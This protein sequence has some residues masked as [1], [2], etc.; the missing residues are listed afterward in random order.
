MPYDLDQEYLES[1]WTGECPVSG[2]KLDKEAERADGGAAELDRINPAL[3]Y[4]KG[5]VAFLSR[6]MNRVKSDVSIEEL[7]NLLR[8]MKLMSKKNQ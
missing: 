8:W 7:E 6:K 1:I 3:G 2:V 4:T 5:N